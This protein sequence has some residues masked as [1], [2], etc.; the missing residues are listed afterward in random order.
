LIRGISISDAAVLKLQLTMKKKVVCITGAGRG[1]GRAIAETFRK[2]GFEVIATDIDE[3]LLS[4][5][6]ETKRITTYKLDV[7]SEKSTA[8]CARLTEDK[9]GRLDV[10]ISCAGIVDYYPLSEAGADKLKKIFDVNTF[11]LINLTKYFLPLL[12]K[13]SGRLIV[14]SSESHKVPAPFQ[15]YTVSKQA[16]EA[17]YKAIKMEL[18]VKNIKCVLIRPGAIQTN[19]LETV[20]TFKPEDNNGLLQNEFQ[21]FVQSVSRYMGKASDPAEVARLIVK[22]AGAKHPKAVYNI[23]HHLLVSLLSHLPARL[24]EFV[25]RKS[26]Q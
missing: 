24:K 16:L 20:R 1:L 5:V 3:A 18:S 21:H 7:T 17:V 14:I 15:P 25:V 2:Q 11:G 9:F 19:I 22:A 13:S 4:E 10:L 23:N 26:L 6:K 12:I 8:G